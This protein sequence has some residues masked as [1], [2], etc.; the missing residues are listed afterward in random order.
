[1]ACNATS[2][3]DIELVGDFGGAADL[4]DEQTLDKCSYSLSEVQLTAYLPA[5]ASLPV[6]SR[7]RCP[8]MHLWTEMCQR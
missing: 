7:S 4:S 3:T 5:S 8:I 2:R 1:M 6:S